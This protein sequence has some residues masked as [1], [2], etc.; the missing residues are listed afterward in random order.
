FGIVFLEAWANA[1]PVVAACA[2]GVAEVVEHD[3]TGLLIEYG[4]VPKLAE[5]LDR[6]MIDPNLAHRLGEAGRKHVSAKG[7][8][9]DDRFAALEGRML[10]L[11]SG[12]GRLRSAG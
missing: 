2:G 11:A 7:Y 12:Q 10:E 6:L 5:T 9:W 1:K 8:T 3:R 4:D